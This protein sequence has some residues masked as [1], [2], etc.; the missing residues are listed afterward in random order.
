MVLLVRDRTLRPLGW[1]VVGTVA[2]YFV[3]RR[4]VVKLLPYLCSCSPPA[5][6]RST[7]RQ[8][9]AASKLTGACAVASWPFHSHAGVTT[10][11]GRPS[12]GLQCAR[13]LPVGG[14][15]A[16]IR[17]PGRIARAGED[18][19]VADN[20]GEAGALQLFGHGLPPVASRRRDDVAAGARR[21]REAST[22]HRLL[23]R[24]RRLLQRLSPRRAHLQSEPTATKETNS[25][26]HPRKR[27]RQRLAPRHRS[28]K[29]EFRFKLTHYRAECLAGSRRTSD[30]RR[31]LGACGHLRLACA[32]KYLH[33]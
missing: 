5:R 26:L 8:H 7:A 19:I 9:A 27:P 2:A 3:L 21:S 25:H 16:H 4:R 10:A 18:V 31:S 14:R 15:L 17:A 23:P 24:R 30:G 11:H 32:S 20:Y 28:T 13:G 12:R 29:L 1:T 33:A 22:R 6:S